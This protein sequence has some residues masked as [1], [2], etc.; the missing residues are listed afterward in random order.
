MA[1]IVKN[2][3][4]N[5]LVILIIFALVTGWIFSGWP[6]IW[7]K[8]PIPPE[9]QEAKAAPEN[10]ILLWDSDAAPPTG[11]TCISCAAG[12]S[13]YQVFPRGSNIYG[14]ATSGAPTHIHTVS[15][16][17]CTSPGVYAYDDGGVEITHAARDHI[18]N[19]I[20]SQT[21]SAASND[22]PYR[23]LKFISTP[24][25]TT[26]PAGVIA[27]FDTTSLPADWNL[28]TASDNYYLRGENNTTTGGLATHTHQV[29]VTTGGPDTTE[30]GLTASASRVTE[31]HTH[32]GSATSSATANLPPYVVAVFA[33]ASVNTSL[34]TGLISMFDADPDADWDVISTTTGAYYQ[35]FIYA[36]STDPGLIGGNTTSTHDNLDIPLEAS[37]DTVADADAIPSNQTGTPLDHT[38]T[39][40]VSFAATTTLP[41][42]RDTIFAKYTPPAVS[43]TTPLTET[44]FPTLDNNDV[45]TSSPDATTTAS[46]TNATGLTMKIYDVGGPDATGTPSLYKSTAPTDNIGSA[47]ASYADTAT[48]VAGTEG[49]GIQATTTGPNLN[50]DPRFLWT[51]N[52]V[53]GLEASSTYAVTLASSSA[54]VADEVVTIIH[55]AAASATNVA[56]DYSDTITITCTVNP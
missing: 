52:N 41:V 40:T 46:T 55:K 17:S 10:M 1:K 37:A 35:K 8:P 31:T 15:Y 29:Q 9:I 26:I 20:T 49:Y 25:T 14:S 5:F 36:S 7:Q 50:I 47:D 23:N 51:G 33:K 27:L 2:N 44:I 24:A 56:G 38:H 28:Y 16:V 34:P 54:A 22:P 48:L 18:H 3:L 6:Q 19:T 13:F 32:T 45:Y 30:G 4:G 11:W 39:M 42:Y 21:V 12:D 53:G 43:C